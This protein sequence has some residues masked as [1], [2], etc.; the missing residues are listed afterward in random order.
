MLRR[1]RRKRGAGP[2]VGVVAAGDKAGAGASD[3]GRAGRRH[4]RRGV[5]PAAARVLQA[6]REGVA[7][8]GSSRSRKRYRQEPSRRA[9]C[10][11]QGA[12]RWFAGEASS[13]SASGY[14]SSSKDNK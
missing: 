8:G 2:R 5:G 10:N 13:T 12:R 11:G 14:S 9:R 6:A 7:V 4:G 1:R 3:A